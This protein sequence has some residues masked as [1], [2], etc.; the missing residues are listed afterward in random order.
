[1]LFVT[2]LLSCNEEIKLEGKKNRNSEGFKKKKHRRKGSIE[3][4]RGLE[5]TPTIGR[6]KPNSQIIFIMQDNQIRN[7]NVSLYS[8]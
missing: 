1:M 8:H 2:R 6:H 4:N 5:K 7:P 3:K